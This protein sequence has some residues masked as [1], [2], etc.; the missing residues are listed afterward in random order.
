MAFSNVSNPW[1]SKAR[2]RTQQI[3][4]VVVGVIFQIIIIVVVD[5]VVDIIILPMKFCFNLYRDSYRTYLVYFLS[6]MPSWRLS[7][8]WMMKW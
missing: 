2:L 6:L 3:H 5:I 4:A 1:K 8:G 7:K